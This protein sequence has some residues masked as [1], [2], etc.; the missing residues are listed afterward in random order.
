MEVWRED[1]GKSARQ[2]YRSFANGDGANA[3]VRSKVEQ[4]AIYAYAR[5][6]PGQLS[7]H[8]CGNIDGRK[9]FPE[10]VERGLFEVSHLTSGGLQVEPAP[11]SGGLFVLDGIKKEA[12]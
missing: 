6:R 7:P 5:S 8:R 4:V 9:R 1:V 12:R 10:N 11:V 2:C 3:F